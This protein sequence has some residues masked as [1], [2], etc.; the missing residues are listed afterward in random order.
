MAQWFVDSKFIHRDFERCITVEILLQESGLAEPY[1]TGRLRF[2]SP[3]CWRVMKIFFSAFLTV[4]TC[5]SMTSF[6]EESAHVIAAD[7]AAER[8]VLELDAP[9]EMDGMRIIIAFENT[10]SEQRIR[11]ASVRAGRHCYEMRHIPEWGRCPGLG[12]TGF[13]E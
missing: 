2:K 4:S 1:G 6:A 7:F 11:A 9:S 10:R 5:L 3:V 12:N 8:K 13:S